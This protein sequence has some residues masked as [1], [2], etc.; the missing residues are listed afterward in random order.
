V[1]VANRGF[2]AGTWRHA[3]G[4]YDRLRLQLKYA[5][6]SQTD[7]SRGDF[8]LQGK[9]NLPLRQVLTAVFDHSDPPLD[10][11]KYVICKN[12]LRMKSKSL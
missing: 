9:Q 5:P 6:G 12:D 10:R 8:S 4:R 11:G 3:P 1:D 7:F 2:A